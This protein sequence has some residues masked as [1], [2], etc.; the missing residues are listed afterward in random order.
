[1]AWTTGNASS[2]VDLLDK[3]KTYVT[4]TVPSGDQWVAERYV[5][6]AGA[7]ELILRGKGYGAT[8]QIYAGL[9]AYSDVVSDNFAL[10]LNG[11]TGYNS[12][13][14]FYNM[15]GA[16]SLAE[17]P[18]CLPSLSSNPV[19]STAI[20]YWFIV[21]AESIKIITRLGTTYHQAYLGFFLIYGTPPQYSY[22]LCVGGSGIVNGSGVPVKQNDV[23]NATH[24][25]WKPI[26]AFNGTTYNS[27]LSALAF[28]D[29]AGVWKRLYMTTSSSLGSSY[30]GSFPYAEGARAYLG[31]F[32]NMRT[33]LDGSYAMQSIVIIE[34]NPAN[35]YGEFSGMKHLTGYQLNPEDEVT[36]AGDTYLVIPN[37][38]RTADADMCAYRLV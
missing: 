30:S 12:L 32:D 25:F 17:L 26:D 38:F 5:T 14:P 11:F 28:K 37:V 21:D 18:T 2:A 24:A 8:D 22:R 29:P 4:T 20:K 19:N 35:L 27:H 36:Y 10:I 34:G 13:L 1:M 7:E 33:N 31:G 9:K 3:L 15:P 16:M 23:T 6:T